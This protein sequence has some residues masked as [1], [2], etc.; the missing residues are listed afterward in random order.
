M[1]IYSCFEP[2]QLLDSAFNNFNRAAARLDQNNS[3]FAILFLTETSQDSYFDYL[4]TFAKNN[5][6]LSPDL[7]IETT[8]EDCSLLL[9]HSSGRV[10]YLIAGPKIVTAEDLEDLEVL[11]LTT[12]HKYV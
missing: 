3:Y 11:A 10:L 5:T 8:Q 6:Q 12:N 7:S 9:R 1:H 2:A 4:T